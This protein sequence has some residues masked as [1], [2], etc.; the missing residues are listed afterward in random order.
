M[1]ASGNGY[2]T[3]RGTF[4]ARAAAT[5]G[6]RAVNPVLYVLLAV[7]SGVGYILFGWAARRAYERTR[8]QGGPR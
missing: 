4:T 8:Q 6:V 7:G 3:T 5:L 1:D 2:R